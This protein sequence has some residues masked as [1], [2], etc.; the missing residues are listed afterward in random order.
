[1]EIKLQYSGSANLKL[2][3]VH[4]IIVGATKCL[5]A[6][7]EIYREANPEAI[8]RYF[9]ENGDPEAGEIPEELFLEHLDAILS[10]IDV[11]TLLKIDRDIGHLGSKTPVEKY[12]A[13][14]EFLAVLVQDMKQHISAYNTYTDAMLETLRDNLKSY[15]GDLAYSLACNAFD[16]YTNIDVL[17]TSEPII[18]D[19]MLTDAL[20]ELYPGDA[21]AVV[22]YA[23]ELAN[24]QEEFATS[25][26]I[27]DLDPSSW[28]EMLEST[29]PDISMQLSDYGRY[30]T[31]LDVRAFKSGYLEIDADFIDMLI[32]RKN[33]VQFMGNV[34]PNTWA[35]F[36]KLIP[37]ELFN[38]FYEVELFIPQDLVKISVDGG[39]LDTFLFNKLVEDYRNGG[40]ADGYT[41]VF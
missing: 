33:C 23:N 22:T 7:V 20:A 5:R 16:P 31:S 24:L 26:P 15:I 3:A 28:Q 39:K 4:Q 27:S 8:K 12:W 6:F 13:T 19:Q 2:Q 18:C 29:T 21:N 11:D 17:E 32:A 1:M 34:I 36:V 9:K 14:I 40:I 30:I 37:D 35:S 41:A 25:A 10:E 38:D